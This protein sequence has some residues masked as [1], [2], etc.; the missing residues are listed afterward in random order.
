MTID[1]A[2]KHA[3]EV[4]IVNLEKTKDRN[5]SDPIAIECGECAD[6]HR[7]LAEWLKELKTKREKLDKIAEYIDEMDLADMTRAEIEREIEGSS[8][9]EIKDN[10]WQLYC[11]ISDISFTLER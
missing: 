5:A 1:E 4:M 11:L 2:I 9:E 3:E 10:M 7:Q 6:E 8:I